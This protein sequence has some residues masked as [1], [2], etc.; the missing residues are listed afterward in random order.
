MIQHPQEQIKYQP[1]REYQPANRA[2]MQDSLPLITA[3]GNP[4]TTN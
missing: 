2:A 4:S 1:A 3:S